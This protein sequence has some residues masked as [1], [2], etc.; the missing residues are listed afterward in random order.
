MSGIFRIE[1]APLAIA[2]LPTWGRWVRAIA[3]SLQL[4]CCVSYAATT[5][6]SGTVTTTAGKP[7]RAA[8]TV[9]DVSTARVQGQTPFDRQYASKSDGT[10][11]FSNVPAGKYQICVEAPHENVLDPCL[12]S[13]TVNVVDISNGAPVSGLAI[14]VATGYML[15]VHVNDPAALLPAAVGGTAGPA[16]SVMAITQTK[17][18]HNFHLLGASATAR[19]HYLLVPF[20]QTLTLAIASSSLKL[21]NAQN[22]RYSGDV[23]EVPVRI[24]SGGSLGP[25]VVNVASR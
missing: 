2:F 6:I 20:D 21:S 16:L 9:H 19:D 25:V 14:R 12:W 18:Y 3:F 15:Q 22:Q 11:L 7:I 1:G 13:P 24:P 10:F 23:L 4:S 17:Q 8:V 5:T